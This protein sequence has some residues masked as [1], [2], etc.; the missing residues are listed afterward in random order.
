MNEGDEVVIT[1][2][3]TILRIFPD[4][5]FAIIQINYPRENRQYHCGVPLSVLEEI[6]SVEIEVD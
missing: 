6:S 5:D 1:E 3:I 4:H 2:A